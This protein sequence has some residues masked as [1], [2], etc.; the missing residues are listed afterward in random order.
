MASY[1]GT[2]TRSLL[3]KDMSVDLGGLNEGGGAVD[4]RLGGPSRL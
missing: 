1:T 2:A 4:H 3:E